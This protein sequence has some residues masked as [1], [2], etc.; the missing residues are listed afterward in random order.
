[1]FNFITLK[2]SF[3]TSPRQLKEPFSRDDEAYVNAS[4]YLNDSNLE[5]AYVMLYGNLHWVLLP[6]LTHFFGCLLVYLSS[7][8][9]VTLSTRQLLVRT[10]ACLYFVA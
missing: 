10:F 3:C 9:I 1:M 5:S 4:K 2:P 8:F 6:H 7:A